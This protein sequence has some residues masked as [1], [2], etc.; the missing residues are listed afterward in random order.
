MNNENQYGSTELSLKEYPLLNK[1][2]INMHDYYKSQIIEI[3]Y[4]LSRK[5]EKEIEKIALQLDNTLCSLKTH[6]IKNSQKKNEYNIYLLQLYKLLGETRDIYYGKGEQELSYMQVVVW[7]K[8]Y[9]ILAIYAVHKYVKP[10]KEGEMGYGSWRDIKYL[11][12]YIR[13]NTEEGINHS[14]IQYCVK[15]TNDVLKEDVEKWKNK[16]E[17]YLQKI[18]K[19][20]SLEEL[21]LMQRPNARKEISS[22]AKWI[23]RE[24]KRFDWL[25]E[26]LVIDWYN[27]YEAYILS[28]FKTYEG[29]YRALDKCKMKYRKMVSKLNIELDTTEIKQCSQKWEKIEPEKIPQVAMMRG[30]EGLCYKNMGYTSINKETIENRKKICSQQINIHFEKK[31]N[32]TENLFEPNREHKNIPINISLSY[33]VREAYNLLYKKRILENQETKCE[34]SSQKINLQIDIL[35][36]QWKQMSLILGTDEFGDYIPMI[37]M[38]SQLDTNNEILYNTIGLGL[39]IAERSSLGK[40]IMVIDH[41]PIWINMENCEDLFSMI[42]IIEETTVTK[43]HTNYNLLAGMELIVESFIETNMPYN[44]I[45]QLSLVIIH[46]NNEWKVSSNDSHNKIVDIFRKSKKSSHNKKLPCPEIIYWNVSPYYSELPCNIYIKNTYFLSG[47]SSSQI[48]ILYLI[49]E[50]KNTYELIS[51]ILK[52]KRY[53]ELENYFYKIQNK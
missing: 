45:K 37:D 3:Y 25:H 46:G 6:M 34:K 49:N 39:L 20:N 38:S 21:R 5:E 29:Y 33:Y 47:L 8:Y 12:D 41:E 10:L 2:K 22:I 35:N 7:Y 19:C 23:P 30:K 40:R 13:K 26:K 11:C 43:S 24:N 52:N 27:R 15:L 28:S 42:N 16:M 9:P 1:N 14:L 51:N 36:K 31:Y 18:N 50:T 32:P 4:N 53:D 44:K 17:D 48:K